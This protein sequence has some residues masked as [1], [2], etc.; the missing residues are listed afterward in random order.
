MRG[1]KLGC[2]VIDAHT[3][4]GG[5]FNYYHIPYGRDD[6]VVGHMDVLGIDEA[7]AFS[8]AG[9][10]SDFR[11]GN[12]LIAAAVSEFPKRLHG[13]ATLNLN[14]PEF[15]IPEL[16]RCREMG[17]VG[18]KIIGEY[19]FRKTQQTALEPVYEYASKHE[20]IMLNHYWGEP[21]YLKGIALGNA[22]ACFVI[23]HYSLAYAEVAN[24]VDNVYQCTCVPLGYHQVEEMVERIDAKKIVFG[25]DLTDLDPA[26]GL[27]PIA[28]ADIPDSKKRLILGKNMRRVLSGRV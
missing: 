21:A 17:L 3:H 7:C 4:L 19:Q 13:F 22:G 23:G 10:N 28:Y 11:L 24:E 27:A 25:S 9:V 1:D 8:F 14:Y 26:L 15:W 2:L 18:V 16:E 12:D 20:M 6:E 5:F